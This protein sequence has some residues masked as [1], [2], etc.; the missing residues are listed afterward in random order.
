M[1]ETLLQHYRGMIRAGEINPDPAQSLAV[2]KLQVLANQLTLY[3]PPKK[4]AF[5]HLFHRQ[6]AEPPE[7]LYIF[8]GVGRGKTMLMDMFYELVRF[9]SKRRVHFHEFMAEAHERIAQARKGGNGDPIQQVAESIAREAHLLCFDELFVTD[10]AAA[11]ILGRLFT[12]L[13]N[14]HVV[15]VATSNLPPSELYK[16]G[17]NRALFLPFIDLIETKMEVLQ[18]E[19]ARDYRLE[20]LIGSP[21]YF[22]PLNG[23]SRAAVQQAWERLTGHAQGAP[24]ELNVHGRK[25]M[26]PEVCMG[27]ARFQF[28]ELFEQPLGPSDYLAIA[29]LYHTI[30]IENIPVMGPEKRNQARR[31]ITFID[32]LYD[33]GAGLI[34][35]AEGEPDELYRQGDG[36]QLFERTASR[37]MEMR[38][39]AY[40]TAARARARP[41]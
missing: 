28:A 17:L 6:R 31:F 2:E 14:A 15:I 4:T 7:G 18:L 37:L 34:V 36:A 40:L 33:Q 5:Y 30:F 27:A 29:H 41:S 3:S 25:V 20:K 39:D 12:G 23:A 8:G 35:S 24:Q 32:T 10:I 38:S 11:M 21:H 9:K 1:T 19:A 26:A 22:T 16:G 13:F